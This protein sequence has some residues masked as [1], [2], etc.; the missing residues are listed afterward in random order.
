MRSVRSQ[1]PAFAILRRIPNAEKQTVT[2][3]AVKRIKVHTVTGVVT[4]EKPGAVE[5]FSGCRIVDQSAQIVRSGK[6][7]IGGVAIY[8]AQTGNLR[9]SEV[10]YGA[11]A[12]A[13]FK[14]SPENHTSGGGYFC[15]DTYI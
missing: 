1:I 13:V 8:F 2:T 12:G 15:A 7:V 11:F 14:I 6:K 10:K 9:E 3:S 5:Q 4:A